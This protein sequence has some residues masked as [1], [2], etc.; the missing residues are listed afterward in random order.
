[1]NIRKKELSLENDEDAELYERMLGEIWGDTVMI[2]GFEMDPVYILRVMDATAYNT[3]FNDWSS[4]EE[5]ENP[6]WIC[7]ECGEDYE[8]EEDAEECCKED[9]L[10]KLKL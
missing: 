3:G 2:C 4:Q 10:I 8:N 6:L 5:D 1:M 7:G 9:S